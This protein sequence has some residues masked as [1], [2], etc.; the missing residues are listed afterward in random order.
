[1]P[2]AAMVIVPMM[3]IIVIVLMMVIM[4]VMFMPIMELD[5]SA[6]PNTIIPTRTVPDIFFLVIIPVVV[7]IIALL[8]FNSSY[9]RVG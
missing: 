9:H 3:T 6:E 7:L 2:A 8:N 1:M 4:V 5:F